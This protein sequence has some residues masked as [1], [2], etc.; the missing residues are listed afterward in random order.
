MTALGKPL[1]D[2]LTSCWA[3]KISLSYLDGPVIPGYP[4]YRDDYIVMPIPLSAKRRRWRGFNQAEI[5]ARE[6]AVNSGY[7]LLS[8]LV[9]IKHSRPQASSDAVQRWNN[10]HGAFAWKGGDLAGQAVILIDDVATT[11]A[12]LSEA[13]SALRKAGAGKIYALVLAKG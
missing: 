5:L 6:F 1:A 13:A 12:T 2:F 9:R 11:G 3:G 4:R 10:V 8:G 7:S